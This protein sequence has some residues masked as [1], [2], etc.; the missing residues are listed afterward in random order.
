MFKYGRRSKERLITGHLD[1]AT[2]AHRA[3][4]LSK[5]DISV[6]EVLRSHE[7][8]VELV[9]ARK[10]FTMNSR[11]LTGHAMDLWAYVDGK[12]SW[13]WP[14]YY[15]I[16]RAVKAAA[17]ELEVDLVWGGVWDRQLNELSGDFKAET[18]AYTA[19]RKASHPHKNVL[20]DG[21]HF[22]LDWRKYPA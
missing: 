4:Q 10:S 7:R 5:V 19:R 1:L 2:V 15:E 9:A 6:A 17:M 16:A 18:E 11:H 20:L 8:Q 14:H 22:Q 3:L 12:V 21:P 13:E